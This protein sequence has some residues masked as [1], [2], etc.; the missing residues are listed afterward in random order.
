MKV[1]GRSDLQRDPVSKAII[2]TDIRAYNS[3]KQ[4][5]AKRRDERMKMDKLENDVAEMK[6]LM[7]KILNKLENNDG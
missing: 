6:N 2:N 1:E 7:G 4:A 3:A 5:R